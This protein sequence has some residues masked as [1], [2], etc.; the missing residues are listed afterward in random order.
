[1]NSFL[2]LSKKDALERGWDEVDFVYVTGDAYVD[3]PSF[4]AAII[5][6]VMEAEGYRVAVLPSLIGE[7]MTIFSASADLNSD[8]WFR[9]AI[10][11]PWLLTIQPPKSAEVRTHIPREKLWGSDLT[12]L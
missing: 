12:G 6:R 9:R 5:T 4:G 2:P 7:R 8:L 1:M 10:S 3:H 11:T